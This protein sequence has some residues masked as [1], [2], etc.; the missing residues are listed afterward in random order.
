MMLDRAAGK[1]VGSIG[2][3]QAYWEVRSAERRGTTV[4][5]AEKI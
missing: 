1:I 5:S 3:F 2:L 4:R